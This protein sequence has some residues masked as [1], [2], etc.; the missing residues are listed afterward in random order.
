MSNHATSLTRDKDGKLPSYVWPGGYPLFY[1]TQD[2]GILCHGPEC[3][4]G[5]EAKQ[6]ETEC[7]DDDQWR[8]VASDVHWEGA[9]LTCDHCGEEIASA[10]GDPDN[11]EEDA[12]A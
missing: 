8:I 11:P 6:A 1:L 3:A 7:P 12:N 5:P 4:N 10:Y 9:P 2:D